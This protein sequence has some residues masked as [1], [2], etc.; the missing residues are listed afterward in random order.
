MSVGLV[1]PG[2]VDKDEAKLA[3]ADVFLCNIII[4]IKIVNPQEAML[5]IN[6]V[7][8]E[9]LPTFL[10]QNQS[11]DLI[12]TSEDFYLKNFHRIR[13]HLSGNSERKKS[14]KQ[15]KLDCFIVFSN[16]AKENCLSFTILKQTRLGGSPTTVLVFSLDSGPKKIIHRQ[17]FDPWVLI[18]KKAGCLDKNPALRLSRGLTFDDFKSPRPF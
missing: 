13:A 15:N 5:Y 6:C 11:L 16:R 3:Y 7:M 12:G 14:R 4:H 18:G 17:E 9:N 2:V 10:K 1:A 8:I